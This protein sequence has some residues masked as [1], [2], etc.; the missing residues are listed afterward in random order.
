MKKLVLIALLSLGALPTAFAS[1]CEM[2]VEVGDHMNFPQS[3][4][5]SKSAC[6]SMKVTITHTGK[7]PANA[8]GHN[9]VLTAS[10]D[11]QA[12][13]QAGW[14]AGLASNYLPAGDTRILAATKIVGGGESDTITFDTAALT[15]G[16][17]YTFFCSFVGHFAMMK[18]KFNV[19]E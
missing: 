1:A 9:W 4:T 14:G 19:E 17:D 7:I 15:A 13:A 8:M 16:G 2:N 18:G 11:A 3:M 12:V 6:P 5:I 10:A